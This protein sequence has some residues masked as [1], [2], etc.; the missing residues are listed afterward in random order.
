MASCHNVPRPGKRVMNDPSNSDRT[1]TADRMDIIDLYAARGIVPCP[2]G[3]EF[4]CPHA[5]SCSMMAR[6]HG[7]EFHTG[8]WP[9]VGADYGKA[10]VSGYLIR[11]LF[12]A[13]ERGGK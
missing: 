13:M 11:V 1:E 4:R 12:V 5:E 7:R 6:R 8:T 10:R 9:Y 3:G 2:H